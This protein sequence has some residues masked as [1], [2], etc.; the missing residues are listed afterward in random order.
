MHLS[1]SKSDKG[2][3]NIGVRT[4]HEFLHELKEAV[5]DKN[6]SKELKMTNFSRTRILASRGTNLKS[7]IMLQETRLRFKKTPQDK[8]K[9]E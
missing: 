2:H 8:E 5:V 6:L 3:Y 7:K 1:S 9:L 4:T